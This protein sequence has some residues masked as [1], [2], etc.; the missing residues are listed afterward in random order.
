MCLAKV[1][2]EFQDSLLVEWK[3]FLLR[4]HPEPKSLERF[5]SYTRSWMRPAEQPDAGRF[6]VWSTEEAPPSH[7]VPPNVAVKAAA[8][9]GA[10]E[11]FHLALMDAYFY[12]NR[13]VTERTTIVDVAQ[14]V[15]LDMVA[16]ERDLDDTSVAAEV[17]RD[18]NE[19]VSNGIHSVPTVVVNG[20]LPLPGAQELA[21][22]RRVVERGLEREIG[23]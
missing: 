23:L 8:R 6:R 17:V 13:N 5:K 3:S 12:G 14:A 22:Y 21:V 19:A 1:A 20:S 16:F 7:S 11:R 15:G 9:Q 18:H 4:P 10:F 2:D